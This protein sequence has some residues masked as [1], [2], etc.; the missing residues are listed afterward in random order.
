MELGLL[1]KRKSLEKRAREEW[2]QAIRQNRKTVD[3]K[4]SK[5]KREEN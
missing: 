5:K 4:E 3:E 1:D 2:K